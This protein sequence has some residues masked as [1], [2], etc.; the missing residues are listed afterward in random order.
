MD[1][2]RFESVSRPY[3][4]HQVIR[5]LFV[6]LRLATDARQL[7]LVT[8]LDPCIDKVCLSHPYLLSS[9]ILANTTRDLD[10]PS[11]SSSTTITRPRYLISDL[12]R[13]GCRVCSTRT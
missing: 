4:F 12:G 9:P 6:P 5:G 2:G 3:S 10:F 7:E 11:L 1:S 13:T 8:D